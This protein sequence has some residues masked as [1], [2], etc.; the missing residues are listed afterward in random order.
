MCNI[1]LQ[2]SFTQHIN[3][4]IFNIAHRIVFEI[5]TPSVTT[6][7]NFFTI[8]AFTNVIMYWWNTSLPESFSPET[9]HIFESSAFSH[10]PNENLRFY[11]SVELIR[12]IHLTQQESINVQWI[13]MILYKNII[14]LTTWT[15]N[16]F[17]CK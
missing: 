12:V 8:K 6:L 16:I 14:N 5:H 15:N 7:K 4:H 17:L 13:E 11:N 1:R 10:S 2:Y 3:S 9:Y